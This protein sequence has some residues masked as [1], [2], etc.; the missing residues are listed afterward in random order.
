MQRSLAIKKT[1]FH[2]GNEEQTFAGYD[3]PGHQWNGFACPL[4]PL[5]TVR[6]IAAL[7]QYWDSEMPGGYVEVISVDADGNVWNTCGDIKV[8]EVPHETE[9]GP[10]FSIGSYGWTWDRVE[11]DSQ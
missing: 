6:K 4:F 3:R 8:Q 10:L 7:T 9:H 1:L 11:G 5:E 2:I